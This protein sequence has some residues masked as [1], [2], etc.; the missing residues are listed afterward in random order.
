[1]VALFVDNDILDK[2]DAYEL[3]EELFDNI[4]SSFCPI[5]W[6]SSD[7]FVFAKSLLKSDVVAFYLIVCEIIGFFFGKKLIVV[8]WINCDE[9][10]EEEIF[11]SAKLKK[12][13]IKWILEKKMGTRKKN[14]FE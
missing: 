12:N 10:F 2:L 14:M 7:S 6:C 3:F 11:K 5:I 1:M 13:K 8:R 4:E 9:I